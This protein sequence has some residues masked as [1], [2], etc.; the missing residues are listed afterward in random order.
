MIFDIKTIEQKRFYFQGVIHSKCYCGN[1][2]TY[3]FSQNYLSYPVNGEEI[4]LCFSC[5]KC[6]CEWDTPYVI[7]SI[8]I[9]IIPKHV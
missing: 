5:D 7:K 2:C 4:L 8:Q 3:D 9:E 6:G 1:M